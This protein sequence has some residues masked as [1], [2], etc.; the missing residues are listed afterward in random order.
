MRFLTR[1]RACLSPKVLMVGISL[2]SSDSCGLLVGSFSITF[3]R[4]LRYS[5]WSSGFRFSAS[6]SSAGFWCLGL[7]CLALQVRQ[8]CSW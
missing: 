5:A 7:F 4:C 1:P 3:C 6:G 8:P 2:C